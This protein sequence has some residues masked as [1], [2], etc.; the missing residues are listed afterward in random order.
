MIDEIGDEP[1]RAV[2][3]RIIRLVTEYIGVDARTVAM[4]E[5]TKLF[6]RGIGLD[7]VDVLTLVGAVEEEFDL[8]IDDREVAGGRIQTLGA[9]VDMVERRR[10]R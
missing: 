6:G 8:T 10:R 1:R 2:L 9:L 3:A 5:D 4:H 7:S